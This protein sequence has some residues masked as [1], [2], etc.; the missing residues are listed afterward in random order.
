MLQGVRTHAL[1]IWGRAESL[2]IGRQ[3]GEILGF[4]RSVRVGLAKGGDIVSI[5][6][7]GV[8]PLTFDESE[9]LMQGIEVHTLVT[10]FSGLVDIIKIDVTTGGP[11]NSR[12]R[13][14]HGTSRARRPRPRPSRFA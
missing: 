13:P 5:P 4:R 8:G 14:S 11:V 9:P 2:I 7:V 3:G 10:G 6:A 12:G 1:E